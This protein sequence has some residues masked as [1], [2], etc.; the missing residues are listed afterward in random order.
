MAKRKAPRTAFKKGDPNNPRKRAGSGSGRAPGTKNHVTNDLRLH[1]LNAINKAG[2]EQW[3]V[4]LATQNRKEM[5]GLLK[6]IIPS[7]LQVG[8]DPDE[9][10]ARIRE[11]LGE[12]EKRTQGDD[13][14]GR[15]RSQKK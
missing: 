11:Q 14:D 15:G 13:D 7:K 8:P 4:N 2:G 10:A 3:F 1:I 9:S 5:A 12:I 6:A